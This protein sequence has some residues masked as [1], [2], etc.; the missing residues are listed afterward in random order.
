MNNPEEVQNPGSALG[1]AIGSELEKALNNFLKEIV[2]QEGYHFIS[3]G[4]GTTRQGKQRKILV[5]YDRFGTEYKIDAV[6]AN[7]AMQPIIL[8]ESKY[9]RYT[10]H[11][12][13]KGSWICNAHSALRRRYSSIR[14][15]IAVLA[16]NWTTTSLA[17]MN[18]YDINVFMI[19]F[20]LICELLNKHNIEF[21]WREKDRNIASQ[22]WI[23]YRQLNL[24][25]KTRIGEEM[26]D[27]I[28]NN[29]EE[30]VLHI[31]DNSITREVNKISLELHSNLGEV[32]RYEF[33]NVND[34]ISF[35]NMDDLTDAFLTTDSISLFDAPPNLSN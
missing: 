27:P 20:Q 14:S 6:I 10:K 15:S 16:G 4:V 2:E 19:S 30:S 18:S 29:L 5:M 1:E 34:A 32:K 28:K 31:L 23:K 24:E 33:P 35:L 12:R 26:I 21:N 22:A 9:L 17:M 13:D 3:K 7:Q 8:F 25:E 11:N